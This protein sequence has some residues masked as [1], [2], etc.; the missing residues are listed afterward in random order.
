MERL[1]AGGAPLS[2]QRSLRGGERLC[3][4]ELIFWQVQ[5]WL[6]G[7]QTGAR[8]CGAQWWFSACAAGHRHGVNLREL[9]RCWARIRTCVGALRRIAGSLCGAR[10]EA[11]IIQQRRCPNSGFGVILTVD[12]E[13]SQ[14]MNFSRT[15]EKHHPGHTLCPK[16]FIQPFV[17]L[18]SVGT[19]PQMDW[20]PAAHRSHSSR[21]AAPGRGRCDRPSCSPAR[22]TAGRHSPIPPAMAVPHEAWGGAG[23]GSKPSRGSTCRGC[24]AKDDARFGISQRNSHAVAGRRYLQGWRGGN[25][26][27]DVWRTTFQSPNWPFSVVI[28]RV[29]SRCAVTLG[30]LQQVPRVL[31]VSPPY[32]AAGG[33]RVSPVAAPRR[34]LARADARWRLPGIGRGQI[35]IPLSQPM[36]TQRVVSHC[37]VT[38][39]EPWLGEALWFMG[40]CWRVTEFYQNIMMWY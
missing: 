23:G 13:L 29:A 2:G 9:Q 14:E 16:S 25:L 4:E 10:G 15:A 38:V 33:V 30:T 8:P 5:V 1:G 22:Q 20:L 6:M 18:P 26:F 24:C 11:I 31:W 17:P 28:T 7:E 35:Y 19:W 32:Q 21:V 34:A 3:G 40:F 12:E 27:A 36:E 37:L 39:T